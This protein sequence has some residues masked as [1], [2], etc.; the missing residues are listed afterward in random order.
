MPSVTV[1]WNHLHQSKEILVSHRHVERM[2]F[3]QDTEILEAAHVHP[4]ILVIRMS[5]VDLFVLSTLTAPQTVSVSNK[6]VVMTL[7]LE[8]VE[9]T[10]NVAQ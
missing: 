5:A 4:I 9:L 8:L 3:V 6:F 2:H 7:V 10:R 1:D